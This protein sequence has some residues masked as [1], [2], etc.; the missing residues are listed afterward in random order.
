MGLSKPLSPLT[1][2]RLGIGEGACVRLGFFGLVWFGF[3]PFCFN[4]IKGAW[5]KYTLLF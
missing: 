1:S 3:F 5:K 2:F 4:E